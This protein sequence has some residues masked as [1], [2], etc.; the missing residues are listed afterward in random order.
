MLYVYEKSILIV[1]VGCFRDKAYLN[2]TLRSETA[3]W[4][5]RETLQS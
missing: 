4:Y 3:K 2:D 1:T 5:I